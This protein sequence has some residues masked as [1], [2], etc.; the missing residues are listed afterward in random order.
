ML[1]VQ[2]EMNEQQ[3]QED[4]KREQRFFE[5][6]TKSTFTPQDYQQNTIGRRVMKTQDGQTVGMPQK[7]E[8]FI[9]EHGVWRRSQKAPDSE[10]EKRLPKNDYTTQ[11]PVTF[12]TH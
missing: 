9:V 8:Q 12:W 5:T 1:K 4:L 7:D 3:R 2:E 10:L 11:E 6:S